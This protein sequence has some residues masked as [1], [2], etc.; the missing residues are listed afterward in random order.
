MKNCSKC[1]LSKSIDKFNRNKNK[2]DGLQSI[3]IECTNKYNKTYYNINKYSLSLKLIEYRNNNKDKRK[4]YLLNNKDKINKK[5]SEYFKNRKNNDSL[6]KLTCNIR[7]LIKNSFKRINCE[8]K[9]NKS[10]NILGCTF[11]EFKEYLE[12]KFTEGMTWENQ[13][14]WHLDHIKPLSLAKSQEEV[15]IL[16]HYTNFQPLW[17]EDNFKK[18]CKY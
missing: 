8:R 15:I 5:A 7:C 17:A 6:F 14:Q 11:E 16:N 13:G 2:K 4:E 10:E 18:G 9:S 1:K 3:C 12:D